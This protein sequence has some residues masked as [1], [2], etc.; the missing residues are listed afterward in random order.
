VADPTEPTSYTNLLRAGGTWNTG[1]PGTVTID[2]VTGQI[3]IVANGTGLVYARR[4]VTTEV[5]K[6]Y[7]LS[8]SNDTST[9]MFRQI[10]ST[11][12]TADIRAANVSAA[13]DNK[14]EF[15]AITTTTWISFQRTTAATVT[16]SNPIVEEVKPGTASARRL[17][18]K[19][20]YFS[21]D[22]QTS[23]LRISNFN[24]YIGGFV[25][26]TYMPT[27]AIYLMDFGR[28]DPAV[29][30]GGAARVRL[31]WDP[32]NKKVA[33]STAENTGVNYRENYI[34][35]ELQVDTWYY[36]GVTALA[37][38]DVLLRIGTQKAASYQGTSI[39]PTST[40]EIC[41][42]LQVGAR[43]ANPRTNYAPCRF[44]NWVWASNWIPSDPQINELAEGKTPAQIT[45][46]TVP[47]GGAL[48]H[49][50]MVNATGNE[51]SLV[52]T[53]A[54]LVS[55]SPYTPITTLPG[56]LLGGQPSV[57]STVPLDI[58]VT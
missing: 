41:R 20:Q 55:N 46:L 39:P 36:I 37:N 31:F 45:G 27:A 42:F 21:L 56:P 48:Y 23:G 14:I 30:A 51:S 33:A 9:V 15:T 19:N 11:E 47:T 25:A 8:W 5:N 2:A 18:G 57:A 3:T 24:W 49:W 6:T 29:P 34:I 28:L 7:L 38:A 53:T 52:T 16:V 58:I 17:N 26:F 50:P 40:G 43:V 13:G 32:D 12:E 22:A 10:G 54:P 4:A 1:G 44:S 35:K